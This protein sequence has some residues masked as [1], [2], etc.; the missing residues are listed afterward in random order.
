MILRRIEQG[1]MLAPA[2]SEKETTGGGTTFRANKARKVAKS[3]VNSRTRDKL[4]KKARKIKNPAMRKR[5]LLGG[6]YPSWHFSRLS[7]IDLA[8][9][10]RWTYRI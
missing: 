2:A 10:F 4:L 3:A 6:H 5:A 7:G 9:F 8:S 1:V